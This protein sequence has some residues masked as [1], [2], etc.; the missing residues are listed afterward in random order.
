M[1]KTHCC[2]Q[3][4]QTANLDIRAR[5][6]G[7]GIKLGNLACRIAT[8]MALCWDVRTPGGGGCAYGWSG[9]PSDGVTGCADTGADT[10]RAAG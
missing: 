10:I 7:L 1:E 2:E 9:A 5:G 6:V 3:L 4:A 8:L